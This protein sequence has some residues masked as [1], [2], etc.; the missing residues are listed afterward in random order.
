MWSHP[1]F[2]CSSREKKEGGKEGGKEKGVMPNYKSQ[3]KRRAGAQGAFLEM[4]QEAALC[5]LR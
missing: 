4:P 1:H 2:F 3:S 5:G